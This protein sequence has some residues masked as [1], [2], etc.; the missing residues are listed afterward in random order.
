MHA[1][2]VPAAGG[3]LAHPGI[4]VHRA[5][6][7]QMAV[8]FGGQFIKGVKQGQCAFLGA[9]AADA[10]QGSGIGRHAKLGQ[11]CRLHV[12][13]FEF[14]ALVD[15]F[16]LL[17]RQVQPEQAHGQ[18]R[19]PDGIGHAEYA[20]EARVKEGQPGLRPAVPDTGRD[21]PVGEQARPVPARGAQHAGHSA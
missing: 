10:A 1:L 4:A 2:G 9:V 6:Q 17:G 21:A 19:I 12:I 15:R 3:A 16:Q 11:R 13:P 14:M 5:D 18:Q 7:Q 8:Q 20:V